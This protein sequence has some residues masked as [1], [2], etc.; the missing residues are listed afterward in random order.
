MNDEN[1]KLLEENGWEIECQSPFEIRHRD[2]AF[3]TLYGI[4]YVIDGL[5]L[6]KNDFFG[7]LELIKDAYKAE[8]IDGDKF[9]SEVIKLIEK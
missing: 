8:L 9:I 7:K 2:G 5:R 6:E 3:V 1:L 4:Q